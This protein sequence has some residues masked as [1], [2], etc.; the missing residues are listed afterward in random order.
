MQLQSIFL[1][2]LPALALS[3]AVRKAPPARLFE[4]FRTILEFSDRKYFDGPNYEKV[5]I[6]EK[7]NNCYNFAELVPA[8]YQKYATPLSPIQK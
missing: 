6:T 2:I 1:A 8:S 5:L 3:A 4:G 7:N